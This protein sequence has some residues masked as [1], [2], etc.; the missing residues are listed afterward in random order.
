MELIKNTINVCRTTAKGM[1]QAMA[2]GDVIVPDIK[3]DIL[4]LLE[5]NSDACITDK[6]IE[7]GRLVI[8]GRVDYKVLYVPDS[9]SE[10]IKNIPVSMEFR[11]V[12]DGGGADSD[13]K[14]ILKPTVERVEFSTVNSRKL[15]LRAIVHI[16]YEI[17]RLCNIDICTDIDDESFEKLCD[18]ISF[19]DTVDISEHDFTV[20]ETVE[21]PNGAESVSEILKTDVRIYDTEYKPVTG[22][23][24]VK[25]NLGVCVL[26]TDTD[27]Q[28]KFVESELPFT[29]VLDAEGV[30][31]DTVCDIDYCVLGV[32]SGCE[33]DGDGDMRLITLDVDVSASLRCTETRRSAILNDC[34]MPYMKTECE[35]EELTFCVTK[36]RPQTQNTIRE[37]IELPQTAPEVGKV[38]NVMT[39]AVITKS[40]LNRNKIICEG[41]VEAYI[42][43][44]TDSVEN[45]VY[46]H[47]KDIP[48]SYMIE[49]ENDT[50]GLMCEIKAGI[51]HV[52]YNLTSGGEVELRCLLGIDCMLIKEE[53]INNISDISVTDK[54]NNSGIVIYFARVGERVWDIAKRYSV[55]VKSLNA[56]NEMD[57]DRI[58]KSTK[59]FIP[60]R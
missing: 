33:P 14:V 52:S 16:E 4:K 38:Y 54:K 24:I 58:E 17:L 40:E 35:S 55:P 60:N 18:D 12:V 45:P 47:K 50:D 36:E 26:Y 56:H 27:G 28:I 1:T 37:I 20:R 31:E 9:E 42:L 3:P 49:C 39:N 13:C 34:Y 51:K 22:K 10:K 21:V 30:S 2:D 46:S 23:V 8:C 15:R 57:S 6:Y 43:Y 41:R 7:N 53:K 44:L 25:G 59:L 5:V 32:M 48:F 19:E 11:Q 29:E